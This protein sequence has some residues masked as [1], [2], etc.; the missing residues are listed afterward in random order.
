MI[1][2][3][4]AKLHGTLDDNVMYYCEKDRD[5]LRKHGNIHPADFL[6]MTWTAHGDKQKMVSAV[7]NAIHATQAAPSPEAQ[8]KA[9]TPAQQADNGA[10]QSELKLD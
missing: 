3:A 5:F 9:N 10:V 2:K 6:Q 8:T 7:L 4:E 1:R